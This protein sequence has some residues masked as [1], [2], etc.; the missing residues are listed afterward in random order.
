MYVEEAHTEGSPSPA[1]YEKQRGKPM[2]SLHHG[3]IQAQISFLLRRD[4]FNDFQSISELSLNFEPKGAT[5]DLCIYP[6]MSFDYA[7]DDDEVK[8]NEAPL[9]TIEILS[10]KQALEGV[11]TKIRKVYFT[12][13]VKSAWVVLSPL[14][15]IALLLPEKEP[16]F[17][18][19]GKISDPATGIELSIEEVFEV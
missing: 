8:M 17:F 10:P 9:T 11:I 16:A 3:N 2:P 7:K 14:K 12:N 13:G 6:K 15:T 4:Y 19:S 1:S 5:P 18:T